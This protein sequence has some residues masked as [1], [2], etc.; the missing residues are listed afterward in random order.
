MTQNVD[1]WTYG[2][3]RDV[4]QNT[5]AYLI[6]Y[7]TFLCSVRRLRWRVVGVY[8]S[9]DCRA[10]VVWFGAAR[11][12]HERLTVVELLLR[13]HDSCAVVQLGCFQRL[14]CAGSLFLRSF[15]SK[16]A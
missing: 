14:V 12:L 7:S 6:A 1:E 10:N 8:A 15:G 4:L 5:N 3:L 2:S 16:L 11:C 9:S 13:C